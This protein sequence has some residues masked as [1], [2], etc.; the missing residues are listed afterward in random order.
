MTRRQQL[1]RSRCASASDRTAASGGLACRAGLREWGPGRRGPFWAGGSRRVSGGCKAGDGHQPETGPAALSPVAV[2]PSGGAAS[3]SLGGD[4][5]AQGR[6]PPQSSRLWRRGRAPAEQL[7]SP[8][9]QAGDHLGPRPAEHLHAAIGRERH[10]RVG[11]ARCDVQVGLGMSRHQLG[12]PRLQ[13]PRSRCFAWLGDVAAPV[14]GHCGLTGFAAR[15]ARMAA[16]S[17]S[18]VAPLSAA[19]PSRL[20]AHHRPRPSR[21]GV[22]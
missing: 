15:S 14:G 22:S 19:E 13:C 16:T 2:P 21:P 9:P 7:R 11:H 8:P 6:Q 5:G 17:S 4:K 12:A 3:C 10:H 18:G 1:G 20:N